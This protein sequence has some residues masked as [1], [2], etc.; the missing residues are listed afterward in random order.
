MKYANL[1]NVFTIQADV[2][3]SVKLTQDYRGY[4]E[5]REAPRAQVFMSVRVRHIFGE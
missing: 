4:L 2:M 1:R 3:W 5:F